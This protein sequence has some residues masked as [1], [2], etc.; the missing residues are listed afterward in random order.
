[1]LAVMTTVATM[2]IPAMPRPMLAAP[3]PQA[4]NTLTGSQ[5]MTARVTMMPSS[6][7]E[8]PLNIA[9]STFS[10]SARMCLVAGMLIK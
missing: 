7:D 3:K 8:H 10:R 5:I 4:I 9:G 6:E 1:M 2:A